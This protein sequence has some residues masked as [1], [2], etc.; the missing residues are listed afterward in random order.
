[1]TR[2]RIPPVNLA[3]SPRFPFS[4]RSPSPLV[5]PSSHPARSAA[6]TAPPPPPSA[7]PPS[8]FRAQHRPPCAP[9]LVA[10]ATATA[11]TFLPRPRRALGPPCAHRLLPSPRASAR[12]PPCPR[13][14]GGLRLRIKAFASLPT[15]PPRRRTTSSSSSTQ[16]VGSDLTTMNSIRWWGA[17]CLEGQQPA[18]VHCQ[19]GCQRRHE[20]DPH[21]HRRRLAAALP[22]KVQG[23]HRQ[24]KRTSHSPQLHPE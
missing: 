14:R 7:P 12:T 21:G 3:S 20:G 9:L 22:P 8:H 4:S 13:R 2:L 19:R 18:G 6:S 16:D 5:L 24:Q 10:A 1:C 17:P 15:S 23:A 11:T